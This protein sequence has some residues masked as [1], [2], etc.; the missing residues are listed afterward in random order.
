VERAFG[1]GQR[2]IVLDDAFLTFDEERRNRAVEWLRQ[3]C[4]AGGRAIYLTLDPWDEPDVVLE[5]P[6]R[7]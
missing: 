2:L 4:A 7:P 1:E 6:R 5:G 3:W